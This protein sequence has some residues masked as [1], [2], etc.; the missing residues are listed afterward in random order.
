[1]P[2]GLVVRMEP[3]TKDRRQLHPLPL[4]GWTTETQIPACLR[5]NETASGDPYAT[6]SIP[7]PPEVVS[8]NLVLVNW[9]E[10][11]RKHADRTRRLRLEQGLLPDGGQPIYPE[12]YLVEVWR[13][14]AA[15]RP[16]DARWLLLGVWSWALDNVNAGI[17]PTAVRLLERLGFATDNPEEWESLPAEIIIFRAESNPNDPSSGFCWTLERDVAD[18]LAQRQG[19]TVSTGVIAKSDA[20][21]YITHRGESEVIVRREVVTTTDAKHEDAA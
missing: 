21:A 10:V 4:R 3:G 20:L 7:I 12:D 5:R 2:S 1:M 17:A 11:A 9:E 18:S 14:Q 8:Q 6:A 15:G 19:L 16:D 13:L